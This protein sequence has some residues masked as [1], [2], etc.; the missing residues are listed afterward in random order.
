MWSPDGRHLAF[1]ASD[2]GACHLYQV[3]V[4]GGTPERLADGPREVIAATAA[5][6][7]FALLISDPLNIADVYDFAVGGEP[8]APA[9]G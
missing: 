9:R 8:T 4:A 3:A 2:S 1:I 5:A 7:K 6:G